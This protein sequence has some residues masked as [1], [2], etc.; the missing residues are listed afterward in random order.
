MQVKLINCN[1]RLLAMGIDMQAIGAYEQL[2]TELSGCLSFM[3]V[4]YNFPPADYLLIGVEDGYEVPDLSAFGEVVPNG[5]Y[6]G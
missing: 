2:C 4:E 6:I 5:D 3:Y 1:D